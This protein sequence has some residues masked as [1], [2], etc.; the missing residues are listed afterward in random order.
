MISVIGARSS[1]TRA[2]RPFGHEGLTPLIS[3][4]T[5]YSTLELFF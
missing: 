3:P 1:E 5:K 4:R 2:F